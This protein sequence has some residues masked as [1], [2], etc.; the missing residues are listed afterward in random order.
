MSWRPKLKRR[1]SRSPFRLPEILPGFDDH[2]LRDA[3]FVRDRAAPSPRARLF[4]VSLLR[5][6]EQGPC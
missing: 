1:E 5:R 6:Q 3:G 2:L 4:R